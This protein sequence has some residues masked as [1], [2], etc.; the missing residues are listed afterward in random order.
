MAELFRLERR[1]PG[2][3]D[4]HQH[5]H[6]GGNVT[7][8]VI[9]Y[10]RAAA[11]VRYPVELRQAFADAGHAAWWRTGQL[12]SRGEPGIVEVGLEKTRKIK[13]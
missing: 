2:C 11:A 4:S 10:S 1:C 7:I 13:K 12:L 8:A 3:S 9:R 5:V 6:T